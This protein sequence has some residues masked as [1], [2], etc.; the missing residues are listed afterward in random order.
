MLTTTLPWRSR[1]KRVDVCPWLG[2][3]VGVGLGLGLGVGLG[4]GLGLGLGHAAG[5]VGDGARV[6]G[7]G[8]G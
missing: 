4:S 3:G 5:L 6:S 7:H 1:Q 2:L 8:P